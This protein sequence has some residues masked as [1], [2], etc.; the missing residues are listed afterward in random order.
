MYTQNIDTKKRGPKP[1]DSYTCK[2]CNKD[3]ESARKKSNHYCPE[4]KSMTQFVPSLGE[5][6]A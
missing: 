1:K 4:R 5:N 3:F 6:I 2:R